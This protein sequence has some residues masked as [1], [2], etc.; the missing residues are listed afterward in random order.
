MPSIM[1][2]MIIC[3]SVIIRVS[4]M[5]TD[6]PM[7]RD[8]A[9]DHEAADRD[10]PEGATASRG[11]RRIG[12]APISPLTSPQ[13]PVAAAVPVRSSSGGRLRSGHPVGDP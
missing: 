5:I 10:K 4:L 3:R 1:L 9:N 12:P 11:S 6:Q 2:R 7:L 8:A 13:S